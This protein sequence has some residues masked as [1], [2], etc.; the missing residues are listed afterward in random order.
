[1]LRTDLPSKEKKSYQISKRFIVLEVTSELGQ[2][3]GSNPYK[4]KKMKKTND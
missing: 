2:A 1:L 3:S 4:V